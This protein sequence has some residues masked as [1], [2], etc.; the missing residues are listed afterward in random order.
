MNEKQAIERA[1]AEA[2]IHHYNIFEGTSY[3][4][5]EHSDHPDFR[6]KDESGQELLFEVTLSEDRP[7]DI[8]AALGRSNHRSVGEL[9]NH[10]LKVKKGEANPLE[11]VSSL[12]DV[13]RMLVRRILKKKDKAYGSNTALVVRDASPLDWPWD[14][15][16]DEINNDLNPY[17]EDLK[18][19]FDKGIWIVSHGK[20]RI[21]KVF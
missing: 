6:C 11:F 4:I 13:R 21:F 2:F 9:R 18:K 19:R 5:V 17:R 8:A 16:I 20:D 14:Q 12:A 7:K 10:L 3:R 15:A 1:T